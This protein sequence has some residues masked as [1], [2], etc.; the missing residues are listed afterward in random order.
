LK[1]KNKFP[2]CFTEN[3]FDIQDENKVF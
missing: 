2:L 1:D 3:I